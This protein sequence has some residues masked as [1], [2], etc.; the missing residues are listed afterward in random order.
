MPFF[1]LPLAYFRNNKSTPYLY[2]GKY[3]LSFE[4]KLHIL[5]L[6]VDS[7]KVCTK[8]PNGV[9]ENCFFVVDRAQ[10][11][12][13]SDWLMT[14]VGAFDHRGVS[15][16]IFKTEDNQILESTLF[17]GKKS[18]VPRL[19]E[20]EYLVKNVFYRHKKYK[21]FLRT[22]TT[23]LD[24]HGKLQLGLIEYR[25][26]GEE[27]HV[28]PHKNPR[29]GKTF[30]Q[31]APSTREELKLKVRGHQGPSSIFDEVTERS[32]G[33]IDCDMMADMPR[34]VKQIK[35]ARQ[36]LNEK[37]SKNE[38]ARLPALAKDTPSVRNLQWTPNPLVVFCSDE[39][40]HEIAR[41][42]CS[43]KSQSILAIDTTYNVGDFYVTSTSYQSTKFIHSRT[44]KPAILPG[45]VMLHIRRSEKDFKYF[46]NTLLE[47]ND[48]LERIAFV[49]GDRDKAQR[50]F[51][52]PLKRSTFLPCKKHVED[53]IARKLVDLGMK[54]EKT[55]ILADIFGCEKT[56]QK[57]L[58]D[59]TSEDEFLAKVRSVTEKWDTLAQ[60]KTP[61][62]M[63]E[64]SIYFRKHIE[65]DM[66][67]GMLLNVR[68]VQAWATSFFLQRPGV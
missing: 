12:N 13:A 47:Q 39:Q 26:K 63:P 65:D 52:M 55:E 4:N 7:S 27:H 61:H 57:G 46:T 5:L 64:F 38:F 10:L 3:D 23:V 67:D 29:T 30:I 15:G 11:K 8:R 31:T 17:R 60:K 2:K 49:G 58:I 14:D 35:N 42:C 24:S 36:K 21:D 9:Q 45:P 22:A 44:G 18:E 25:Y 20:G 54:D 16:R 1:R 41:E 28:S 32:G 51:L 37:E 53:D 40:L 19:N 62:K 66:R 68:R 33:I 48:Q 56:H 50:G 6:D 34:D 43:T 59:S